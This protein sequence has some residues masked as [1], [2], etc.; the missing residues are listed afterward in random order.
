MLML[1]LAVIATRPQTLRF[2]GGLLVEEDP[3]TTADAIVVS[4]DSSDAG[5][6]EAVDL[7]Q[8]GVGSRVVVLVEPF[9]DAE[10]EFVRRGVRLEDSGAR[11]LRLLA[12]LGFPDGE[13]LRTTVSGT[14]ASIAA[15]TKW[16]ASQRV[17]SVIVVTGAD[18]SRRFRRA[19]QRSQ[20]ASTQRFAVRI[21]RYSG[22]DPN[23]WWQ[24]R[25]SLR[26][27]LIE[28]QK[29]FLDFA[30]HPLPLISSSRAPS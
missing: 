15:I 24:R 29:L 1:G 19:L 6:L 5:L 28:L 18:H 12:A 11:R 21:T 3:L 14:E 13:E 16:A 27:G 2:V 26:L 9:S 30:R 8:K 10:A 25:E 20:R 23:T 17:C 7:V 4:L 22:F